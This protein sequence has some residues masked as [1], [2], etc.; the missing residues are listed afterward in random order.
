LPNGQIWIGNGSAVATP[1]VISG[2][3][4]INTTG[5]LTIGN[6]KVTDSKVTSGAAASGT[7]LTADGSGNASWQTAGVSG[8]SSIH[9]DANPGITGAVNLISGTNVTLTQV[10]NAIT[11]SASGS[12][13]TIIATVHLTSQNAPISATTLYAS[14]PQGV[15][16]AQAVIPVTVDPVGPTI[17][18]SLIAT[19]EVGVSHTIGIASQSSSA[20]GSTSQV[21]AVFN[22][23]AGQTIQYQVTY[24][25]VSDT[26]VWNLY[27]ILERLA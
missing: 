7:V 17:N 8:V 25:G 24:S 20:I 15:Y 27:I 26:P 3:A 12:G 18:C 23:G 1:N 16:R 9:S 13:G 19:D 14:A 4:T 10:S 21:P 6:L 5:V 2:D 22:V 11:I